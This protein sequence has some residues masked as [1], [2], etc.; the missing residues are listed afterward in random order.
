[1]KKLTQLEMAKKGIISTEMKKV[2][3]EEGKDAEEI[4]RLLAEGLIVIP[5]NKNNEEREPIGIGQGLRTKV[6]ANIGS[7]VDYPDLE[8]EIKKARIA[9]EAG[10]DTI[11][12]LSTGGN[13]KE[14]R[15]AIKKTTKLPLGTVPL[16]EVAVEA[17][18]KKGSVI[19]FSVDDLFEVIEEQAKEGV[20]FM[21]VHASLTRF[22]V[23]QLKKEGRVTGIVSRGGAFMTAWMLENNKENPLYEEFD[24]LLEIARTF[25]VTLS[26]GDGLRP[27][28]LA[29]A[30]DRAQISELIISGELTRKAR[31]KGV[32]VMVEGPGHMPLDQI[33]LNV[34]L[35]KEICQGAPFYV[36]GPLVTD[37]TPGYDHIT[38][39]I[40]GAIA[41]ANGADFLCYL[42][43]AEHLGLPTVED[44]RE[45][46]IISRIAAH[47]ADLA[48]GVKGALG[49][50]LKM[51]EARKNLDWQTQMHL[52]LDQQKAGNLRHKLNPAERDTCSMC[53]PFC[54]M[55]IV[56]EYL[57]GE[58]TRC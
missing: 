17:L 55:D 48:K 27:G 53:G 57:G 56:S 3:G 20:D 47:A 40:G 26:L 49:W 2:A 41:A 14:I 37:I 10:T 30:T 58:K 34:K 51:A 31:Q 7:S 24:R 45:G 39:A 52:A 8:E 29:D 42:T 33:T 32:Q 28:C 25:D 18:E 13:I 23:E 6:N 22:G 19:G 9:K 15:Q 5:C 46:V 1:V 44:V 4:R 43:P 54:A 50:D 11:M 35:E 38:G 16:Y 12:D 36:L 21:T